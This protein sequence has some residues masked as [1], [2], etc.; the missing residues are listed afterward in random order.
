MVELQIIFYFLIYGFTNVLIAYSEYHFVILK[1]LSYL[2]LM[3]AKEK[4]FCR[5]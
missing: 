1:T 3:R 2:Q 5:F 4:K